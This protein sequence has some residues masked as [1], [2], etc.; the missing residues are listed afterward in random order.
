MFIGEL[1]AKIAITFIIVGALVG[2]FGFMTDTDGLVLT[3]FTLFGLGVTII[4]ILFL[5]TIWSL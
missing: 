1:A 5:I 4:A 3:G 2:F